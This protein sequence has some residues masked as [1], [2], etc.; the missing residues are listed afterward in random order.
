MTCQGEDAESDL[1]VAVT[2]LLTTNSDN[3]KPKIVW[4]LFFNQ[5]CGGD[6]GVQSKG[7]KS[8]TLKGKKMLVTLFL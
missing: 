6:G 5:V 4:S 1:Q 7:N 3:T 2:R 8:Q